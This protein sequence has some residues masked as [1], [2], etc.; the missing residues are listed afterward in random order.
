MSFPF[1][2]REELMDLAEGFLA[3]ISPEEYPYVVEHAHQHMG[4]PDPRLRASS[5]SGS[6]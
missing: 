1:E 6:T 3:Q 5:S 4:D 2:T